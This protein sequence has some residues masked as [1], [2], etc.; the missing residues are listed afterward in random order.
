[1]FYLLIGN[2]LENCGP[3][4]RHIVCQLFASIIKYSQTLCEVLNFFKRKIHLF[5]IKG[6]LPSC[7]FCSSDYSLIT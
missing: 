1:M 6:S 5:K 2:D 7:Q 4:A 3:P